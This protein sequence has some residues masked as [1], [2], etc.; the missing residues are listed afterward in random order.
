MHVAACA[1]YQRKRVAGFFVGKYCVRA[2]TGTDG[3]TDGVG[4]SDVSV[5]RSLRNVYRNAGAYSPSI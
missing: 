5:M 2:Y 1:A 4:E 3:W